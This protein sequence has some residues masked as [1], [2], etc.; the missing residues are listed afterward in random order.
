MPSKS[1]LLS[2][3]FLKDRDLVAVLVERSSVGKQD[4]V[5]EIGPGQGIITG[6][7]VKRAGKVVAVEKDPQLYN[8]LAQR[9]QGNLSVELYNA[10]ILKFNLPQLPYKVFSNIPFA[11]EGQLIRKLIDDPHNPPIDAYLIMR[12]EVAERLVGVPR[13]GQFSILHKPWFDLEIFHSFQRDDFKPKPKV[14]SSMLRFKKRE[15]LLISR[16]DKRLYELFIKQGFGGGKRLRQNLAPVFT[17]NQLNHLA[18]DLD[19][20]IN[21]MPSQLVFDQW[22]GMF[23]FLRNEVPESQKQKFISKS[24]F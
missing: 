16:G 19:F 20:R 8:R 21:D 18:Q 12:R 10:D 7:L 4:I 6:E 14:E 22:F 24:K 23:E 17:P 5:L 3:V 11:I 2:Q 13:E 15:T 9:Y 1:E